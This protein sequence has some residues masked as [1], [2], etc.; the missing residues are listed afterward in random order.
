MVYC[1]CENCGTELE[2][3][4][5][6]YMPGCREMEE[7]FCPECHNLVTKVFTSGTPTVHVVGK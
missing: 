1:T 7:V 5:N 4:E 3:E 2:V 6:D